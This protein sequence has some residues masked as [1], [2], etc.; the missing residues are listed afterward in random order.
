MRELAETISLLKDT[1]RKHMSAEAAV[2]GL[3]SFNHA[4]GLLVVA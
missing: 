4:S 2:D 3:P 1:A